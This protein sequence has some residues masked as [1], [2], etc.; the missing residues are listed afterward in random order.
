M[1]DKILVQMDVLC[2]TETQLC[3]H[4][5][6][7]L[8]KTLDPFDFKFNNISDHRFSNSAFGCRNSISVAH[9]DCY[10]GISLFTLC[11]PSFFETF[12]VIL[13]YRQQTMTHQEFLYCLQHARDQLND[14]VHMILGDVNIDA[15]TDTNNYL[16]QHLFEYERIN[17]QPTHISGSLI[18]HVYVHES[19]MQEFIIDTD[20]HPIYF[21]DHDAVKIK[22]VKK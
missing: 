21:S 6:E 7:T 19:L 15:L 1:S 16:S 2:L 20:L 17:Q 22:L 18:D 12:N 13:I 11:K 10:P 9:F 4:P 3:S 14:T 8:L 5:N